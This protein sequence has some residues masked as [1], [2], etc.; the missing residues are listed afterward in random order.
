MTL[1][2]LLFEKDIN[3]VSRRIQR[4]FEGVRAA[5]L[6]AKQQPKEYTK[7]WK[8]EVDAIEDDY[9]GTD[10]LAS[11]LR[12]IIDDKD[13]QSSEIRNPESHLAEKLYRAIKDLRYESENVKDPFV[14]KFKDD[15]LE[16]LMDSKPLLA[17][18][19][20]WALRKD[21]NALSIEVWE[22]YLPKGDEITDGYDGLD[23]HSKDIPL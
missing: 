1:T 21:K 20:H 2:G 18:F 12:E 16:K 23:I 6:S 13:I 10:D 8:K 7:D 9:N 17:T 22:N 4:L 5:Y 15:T 11:A 19:I 3:P 14:K